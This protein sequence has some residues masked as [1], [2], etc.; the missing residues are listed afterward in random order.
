[1]NKKKEGT[2]YETV[3]FGARE[4]VP[5]A[6]SYFC[7]LFLLAPDIVKLIGMLSYDR[8]LCDNNLFLAPFSNS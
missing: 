4:K 1:M 7:R 8:K 6:E 5:R 2:S 3:F